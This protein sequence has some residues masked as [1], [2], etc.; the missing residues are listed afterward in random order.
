VVVVLLQSCRHKHEMIEC[1]NAAARR[2]WAAVHAPQSPK[3][4]MTCRRIVLACV[5]VFVFFFCAALLLLLL[6]VLLP[7]LL[8]LPPLMPPLMPPPTPPT[9]PPMMP[10]TPILPLLMAPNASDAT[11]GVWNRHV[12][13]SRKMHSSPR[14]TP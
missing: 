1:S 2:T 9:P 8:P 11:A 7:L 14:T 12:A 5:A 6:G 13:A 3:A 10:P 4:R